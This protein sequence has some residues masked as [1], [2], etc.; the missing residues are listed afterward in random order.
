MNPL[1]VECRECN[2]VHLV[3]VPSEGWKKWQEGG[4]I[5]HCMPDLADDDR[6][7]LL[8]KICGKCFKELFGGIE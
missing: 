4:H 1:M 5:Q 8:S 6:E 3:M 7:L 2:V